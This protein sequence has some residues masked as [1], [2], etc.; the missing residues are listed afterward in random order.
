MQLRRVID[1]VKTQNWFAVG[2]DFII[3]V[4][5]VYSAVWIEGIQGRQEQRQRTEQIIET[6]RS[7][8]RGTEV[9]EHA[10]AEI[11][12]TNMRNWNELEC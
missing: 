11:V 4:V 5:G 3:V 1:H 8:L 7:D 10:F 9:F 2:V 6:L 12:Q